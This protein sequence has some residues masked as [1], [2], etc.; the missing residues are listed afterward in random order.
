MTNAP[1]TKVPGIGRT[2]RTAP[3][4]RTIVDALTLGCVLVGT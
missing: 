2:N 1:A 4:R 3:N